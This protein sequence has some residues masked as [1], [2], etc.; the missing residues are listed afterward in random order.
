MKSIVK[1]TSIF[2]ICAMIA[3]LFSCNKDDEGESPVITLNGKREAF[4]WMPGPYDDPG[5]TAIDP[6]DGPSI[7]I[8]QRVQGYVQH[9]PHERWEG[10]YVRETKD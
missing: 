7:L 2:L 8:K 6:E 10:E 9:P 3:G 4:C 5:C 1:C